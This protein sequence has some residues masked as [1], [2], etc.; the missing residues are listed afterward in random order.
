MTDLISRK[1][2]ALDYLA[3]VLLLSGNWGPEKNIDFSDIFA[4]FGIIGGDFD[5][6]QQ[7]AAFRWL[8]LTLGLPF[9][10]LIKNPTREDGYKLKKWRNEVLKRDAHTCQH[11]RATKRLHAHHI[12]GYLEDISK[13]HDINNGV[14][15]CLPCH[16]QEHRRLRAV[17]KAS[18]Y[19]R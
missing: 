12:I 5:G 13:R 8:Q 7:Y 2:G 11:C 19:G 4:M 17:K 6:R 15:L 10:P 16:Q 1:L 3:E 9:F 14:T 18:L